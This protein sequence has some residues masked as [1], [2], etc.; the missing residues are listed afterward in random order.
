VEKAVKELRDKMA[1]GND[2]VPGDVLKLFGEDSLR[3]TTQLINSIRI[4]NWGVAQ[5]FH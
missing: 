2:E 4:C 3:L 5:R 1:T